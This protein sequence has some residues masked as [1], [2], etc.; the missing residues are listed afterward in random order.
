MERN[1]LIFQP[2]N[3]SKVLRLGIQKL[4]KINLQSSYGHHTIMLGPSYNH[5]TLIIQESYDH[6]NILISALG[7]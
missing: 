5:L 6:P 4:F 1:E 3:V 2:Q 7:S